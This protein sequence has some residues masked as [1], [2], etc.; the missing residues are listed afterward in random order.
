[1]I[2]PS[3][4]GSF[5]LTP[6]SIPISKRYSDDIHPTRFMNDPQSRSVKIN[7]SVSAVT[8]VPMKTTSTIKSNFQTCSFRNINFLMDH[9]MVDK[10][11]RKIS[12]IL[13]C[14][15]DSMRRKYRSQV[16][17]LPVH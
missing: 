13:A 11:R 2:T 16:K 1:M 5:L 15:Q 8:F 3:L 7:H 9:K 17:L 14:L 10:T 6:F 12:F 4:A